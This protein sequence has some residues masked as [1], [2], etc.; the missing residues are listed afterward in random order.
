MKKI[1]LFVASIAITSLCVYADH[2]ESFFNALSTCSSYTSNGTVDTQGVSADYK[3]QIIGWQNDRCLYK[4]TVQFS[5]IDSCVTCNFTQNQINELV[6]VMKAYQTVQAYSGEEPDISDL[7]S[8][9]NNPVVKVWN[10][11]LQDPST[12]SMDI[13]GEL[14]GLMIN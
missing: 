9:K 11:Y 2:D 13:G 6:K 14:K 5:G 10:K 3:S 12:C 7:E 1:L 8:V 4:E